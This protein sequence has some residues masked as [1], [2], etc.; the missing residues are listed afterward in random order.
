MVTSSRRTFV[1]GLGGGLA[2]TGLAGSLAARAT[3]SAP[4]FASDA[5]HFGALEPL[6]DAMQRTAPDELQRKLVRELDRGTELRTLIAAGALA[7][8]R[9]FGGHDYVGYHCA[10]ALHPACR[11][12]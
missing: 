1:M 7:N 6:V 12:S 11:C 9:T 5:L 4:L 2:A 8:A 3:G 10:M